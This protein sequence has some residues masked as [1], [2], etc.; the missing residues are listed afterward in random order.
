MKKFHIVLRDGLAEHNDD[1]NKVSTTISP[2]NRDIFPGAPDSDSY[3]GWLGI[4]EMFQ[5]PYWRRTWIYQEATLTATTPFFCGDEHFTMT[6][7]SATVYMAHHFAEYSQFPEGFR[8]I[9]RSAPFSMAG[10]RTD[11]VIRYGD[12][13]LELLEYL[14]STECSEPRDK[15]YA[16]L[17]M[18]VDASPRSIVPD[19]SKSLVDVYI[20]VAKFSLSQADHG[21]RFLGHVTHPARHWAAPSRVPN[22][23]SWV[24]D[25]RIHSGLN[26]FCTELAD[27]EWAYKACGVKKTHHAVIDGLH[28]IVKGQNIDE[29]VSV[30]AI[31]EHDVFSTAEVQVWTPE[32]PDALYVPS[33]QTRDEAFRTTVFADMNVSAESRGFVADWTLMDANDHTLTSDESSR[34]N[35]MNIALKCASGC[36]SLCWTKCGRVGLAPS[37]A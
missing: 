29:I 18:A 15:V 1:M 35:K 8:S 9:A 17:G 12:T 27:S 32:N 36:R 14:R 23:P 30:N 11:G 10:F 7:V 5:R 19:Y 4:K 22:F 2:E 26:P 3:R 31:W 13:L 25:F 33:H 6:F 16:I 21:L 24:P 34:R 20:D 37:A 28:L